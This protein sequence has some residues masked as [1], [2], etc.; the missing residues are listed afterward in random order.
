VPPDLAERIAVVLGVDQELVDAWAGL[1]R[2]DAAAVR[3]ALL[4]EVVKPVLVLYA[5]PGFPLI[6]R[7]PAGVNLRAAVRRGRSRAR[8]LGVGVTVAWSRRV[9][10]VVEQGGDLRVRRR[11]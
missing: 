8:R 3:R 11:S 1:D 4:D 9:H 2:E 7:L 5:V 6:E 10:V